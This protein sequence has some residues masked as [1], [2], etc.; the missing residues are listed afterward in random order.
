[1]S[2]LRKNREIKSVVT[3]LREGDGIDPKEEKKRCLAHG[4]NDR[5]D[6]LARRLASQIRDILNLAIL[7]YGDPLLASFVVGTVEPSAAGGN[8]VVQLYSVNHSDDYDPSQV[9]AIFNEIKPRL[10]AEV[11]KSVNR[12]KT[13]D[14]KFDV[15]PPRVQPR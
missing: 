11:A 15:L 8:F 4:S 1:M 12:K 2:K 13:P 14:F 10:R 5:R 6:F 9:N 7:Q 3:E